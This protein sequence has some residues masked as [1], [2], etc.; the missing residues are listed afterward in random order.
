MNRARRGHDL[1]INKK[2]YWD[3]L[4]LLHKISEIFHIRVSAYCLMPNHYHLLVQTP[5]MN[6]AR[7]M[8]H[9]NGVFTQKHNSRHKLDGTL[10]KGRYKSILVGE[11]SYL[12]QLVRYIHRN[13]IKANIVD[14]IEQYPWSSHNGYVSKSKQWDWLHKHKIFSM[15]TPNSSQQIMFY[16]RFVASENS[17]EISQAFD[18]KYLPP[19]LGTETFINWVKSS[20]YKIKRNSEIPAS[21]SL[22]PERDSIIKRICRF[23][24]IDREQLLLARRGTENEPRNMAIYLMRV[25]RGDPLM[26]IGAEFNLTGYSSVSSIISRVENKL[27]T[28]NNFKKRCNLLYELSIKGQK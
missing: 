7:G 21:K 1:F 28:D 4:D 11:D 5:E 6:L 14:T 13:P 23:Y 24:D 3:F 26:E 27:K 15:L 16:K 12:L 10:F 2:D 25:L 8:R 9:L 17:E 18:R 19:I 22:S 20:F